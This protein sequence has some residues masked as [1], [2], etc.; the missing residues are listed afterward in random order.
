MAL[1]VSIEE[2]LRNAPITE[3]KPANAIPKQKKL[4]M[5][6]L[7]ALKRKL[8]TFFYPSIVTFFFSGSLR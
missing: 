6:S 1:R 2:L 5:N 7:N 4:S 3:E 8:T